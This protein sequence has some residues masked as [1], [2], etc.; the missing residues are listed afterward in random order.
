[1]L[2]KTAKSPTKQTAIR[3]GGAVLGLGYGMN[4]LGG[5]FVESLTGADCPEKAVD[6]GKEEGTEEYTKF[7]E[8]CQGEAANKVMMTGI[9]V[10][11]VVGLIAV[12]LLR[13]KK[14]E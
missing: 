5:P 12:I 14:S 10:I 1:M 2:L 6:A 4:I 9:A 3:V 13:P 8:D 11:G 7:V